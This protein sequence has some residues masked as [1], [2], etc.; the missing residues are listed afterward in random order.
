MPIF[1]F[2]CQDCGKN[3]EILS[4]GSNEEDECQFCGSQN[5]KKQLSVPSS[6]SGVS[7]ASMASPQ[8]PACCGGSP[9]QMGCAGPG[10]C[11][12]NR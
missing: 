8:V 12:G 10:S 11:C 7:K 6:L 9:D 5:L 2:Q 4:I 3:S 1:E